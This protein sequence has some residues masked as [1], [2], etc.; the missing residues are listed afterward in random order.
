MR[1]IFNSFSALDPAL[2]LQQIAAA[3][4]ENIYDQFSVLDDTR[5]R[6]QFEAFEARQV[7][8]SFSVLDPERAAQ[9]IEAALSPPTGGVLDLSTGQAQPLAVGVLF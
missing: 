8:D 2:S 7:F 6:Q 9:Q 1:E 4:G 3:V 5:A